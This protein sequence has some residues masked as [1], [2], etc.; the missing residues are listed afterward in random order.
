VGGKSVRSQQL[1]RHLCDKQLLRELLRSDDDGLSK[2]AEDR[3]IA[4]AKQARRAKILD[5]VI[6][7]FTL[8][9]VA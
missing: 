5:R 9:P 3:A 1:G 7:S 2:A 4:S 8:V 6:A